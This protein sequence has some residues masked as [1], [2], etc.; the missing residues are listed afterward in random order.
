MQ[1]SMPCRGPDPSLGLS[2]RVFKGVGTVRG[3]KGKAAKTLEFFVVVGEH[4][5][6]LSENPSQNGGLLA[7]GFLPLGLAHSWQKMLQPSW[8]LLAWKS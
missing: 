2:R 1:C 4:A 7:H 8:V 6:N 5:V 3:G